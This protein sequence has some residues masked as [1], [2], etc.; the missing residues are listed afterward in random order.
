VP[1]KYVQ[2]KQLH[3]D[4]DEEEE[5]EEEDEEEIKVFTPSPPSNGCSGK[6]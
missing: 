1:Q 4:D 5:E 6:C 2:K 3:D